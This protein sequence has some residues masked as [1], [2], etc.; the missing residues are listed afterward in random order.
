MTSSPIAATFLEVTKSSIPFFSAIL[1]TSPELPIIMIGNPFVAVSALNESRRP[2]HSP[3]HNLVDHRVLTL[4]TAHH[5]NLAPRDRLA[6]VDFG[7][8]LD[9]APTHCHNRKHT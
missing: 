4:D 2:G 7:S 6:L 5:T 8:S 3:R 1:A 9:L